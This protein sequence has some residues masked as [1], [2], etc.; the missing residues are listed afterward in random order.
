M[1]LTIESDQHVCVIRNG[2]RPE[3]PQQWRS[4]ALTLLQ[5]VSTAKLQLESMQIHRCWSS[6]SILPCPFTH[7]ANKPHVNSVHRDLCRRQALLRNAAH[8]EAVG[9]DVF[10]A[11]Q[12]SSL[13]AALLKSAAWHRS[14]AT[15][16]VQTSAS[17]GG[18]DDSAKPG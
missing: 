2:A 15:V 14:A 11:L 7:V 8:E 4:E 10:I 12:R 17:Q 1:C 5:V 9:E 16:Q 13:L 6:I 18:D 3:A